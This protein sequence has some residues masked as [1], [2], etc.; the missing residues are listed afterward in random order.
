MTAPIPDS[1]LERIGHDHGRH[2]FVPSH[3]DFDEP[4]EL[5]EFIGE[6]P[7]GQMV[8]G[9]G[10]ALRGTAA[11][12]IVTDADDGAPFHLLGHLARRNPHADLVQDGANAMVI[13][14]GPNAYVSPRWNRAN[15]S[16]PTWSYV[17]VQVRGTF[18][19]YRDLD[20][21]RRVLERTIAHME[22]SAERPWRLDDAPPELVDTLLRHIVAFRLRIDD[23][24][25]VKRL[26]QNRQPA[27]RDGIIDGLRATGA[28]GALAIAALMAQAEGDR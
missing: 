2:V 21:T 23:V 14:Q 28:P 12:L 20:A 4:R 22:R 8:S 15:P 5:A 16:L 13:F 11:A 1:L 27:D 3:Y 18:E 24:Q 19:P 9:D 6:H 17:A 25:G 26:N 7:L 10:A